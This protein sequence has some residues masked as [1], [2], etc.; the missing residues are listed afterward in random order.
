MIGKIHLDLQFTPVFQVI[1]NWHG[2]IL[3]KS[4][5]GVL[6]IIFS[7]TTNSCCYDC[8]IFPFCKPFKNSKC[9][10]Y[11]LCKPPQSPALTEGYCFQLY[12][13]LGNEQNSGNSLTEPVVMDYHARFPISPSVSIHFMQSNF[14]FVWDRKMWLFNITWRGLVWLHAEGPLM[15]Q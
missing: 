13:F 7:L 11:V 14:I 5:F 4:I 1:S 9:C 6:L 2:F 15:I 12:H 10:K 3:W 8:I